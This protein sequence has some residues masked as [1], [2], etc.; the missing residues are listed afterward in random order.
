MT[1]TAINIALICG[2]L[3]ADSL[4]LRLVKALQKKLDAAGAKSAY[5]NIGDYDLPLY[6]GDL[7]T[8]V[9][10]QKLIKD[11]K[12]F[13]G[14]I[15]VTPEYNGSLPPVLK[16]AIDWTSTLETGHI[17]GPIYGIASCS[18]GPM[19]GIMAMRELQFLLMRLGAELVPKQV[20]CGFGEKAFDAA[21]NLE[22]QPAST[23]ADVMIAQM[24]ERIARK[25]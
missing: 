13:D 6:H 21:G 11:L 2:S 5:V 10:V 4:N 8:P 15:V 22:A 24:L 19:S 7:E 9:G 23:F 3:R 1:K 25:V 17:T 14:V 20:G 16:N 12:S 18:P